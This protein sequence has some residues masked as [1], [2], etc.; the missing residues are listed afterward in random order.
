MTDLL[1]PVA[2][3]GFAVPRNR[4]LRVLWRANDMVSRSGDWVAATLLFVVFVL[5]L[6]QV[7]SR[8]AVAIPAFWLEEVARI[9]LIWIASLAAGAAVWRRDHVTITAVAD[10]LPKSAS[11]VLQVVADIVVALTA[12]LLALAAVEVAVVLADRRTTAAQLSRSMLYIPL[13]V[14]FAMMALHSMSLLMFGRM[15]STWFTAPASAR[16]PISPGFTDVMEEDPT[17]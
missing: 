1:G 3:S 8:Y 12:A 17:P 13:V 7:V 4:G 5:L 14:G 6:L 15:P 9:G 16:A 2:G 10:A 11:I